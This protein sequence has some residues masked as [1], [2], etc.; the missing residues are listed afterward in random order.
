[1]GVIRECGGKAHLHEHSWDKAYEDFWEAFKNYDEA[2]SKRRIRCLKYLVLANMLS[3]SKINPFDSAEAKALAGHGEIVV[4]TDLV[5]AY[6]SDDIPRFENILRH[7]YDSIM[8]DPFI[9]TYIDDLLTNLRTSV[10]L[11]L[12]RPY[13]RIT[14]PF[15]SQELNVPEDEVERLAVSLILDNRIKGRIDQVNRLIVLTPSGA[16]TGRSQH[17]AID[18]WSHA[19]SVIHHTCTAKLV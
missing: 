5:Q 8:N 2:G 7:N 10:L 18:A 17:A 14:I 11:Q 13:T 4:F 6:S 19:L 12:L 3:S 16:E 9:K 15:V 1:L